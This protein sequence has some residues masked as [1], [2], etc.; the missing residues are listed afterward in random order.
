VSERKKGC[1][2]IVWDQFE[3]PNGGGSVDAGEYEVLNADDP[4]NDFVVRAMVNTMVDFWG[5]HY[6]FEW[7][8]G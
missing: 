6:R 8:E 2:W 3:A 4:D 1:W 7:R 5:D